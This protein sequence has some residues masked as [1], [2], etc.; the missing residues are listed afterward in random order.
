MHL[1]TVGVR[2]RQ[3]RQRRGL[4]QEEMA[5][6]ANTNH[7]MISLVENGR[8]FPT[9]GTLLNLASALN[10]YLVIDLVPKAQGA[11]HAQHEI[12]R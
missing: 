6:R 9:M 5:V 11:R 4:T 12:Q 8:R 1:T 10:C 3:E 7:A 2:F